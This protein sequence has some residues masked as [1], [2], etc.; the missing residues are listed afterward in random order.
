MTRNERKYSLIRPFW[1][2]TS[3]EVFTWNWEIDF[4]RIFSSQI[5]SSS[6]DADFWL[7][8]RPMSG[9]S[10]WKMV[11]K[12]PRRLENFNGLDGCLS[13]R[14]YV[15]RLSSSAIMKPRM[16]TARAVSLR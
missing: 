8:D 7:V 5:R 1:F 15:A 11:G 16:V 4:G 14:L 13:F 2:D 3:V 6:S 10:R 12:Y 9:G